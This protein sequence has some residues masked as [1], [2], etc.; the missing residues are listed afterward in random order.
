V[1]VACIGHLFWFAFQVGQLYTM[2]Q[3][4]TLYRKMQRTAIVS[5]EHLFLVL[6]LINT[7]E[8][9]YKRVFSNIEMDG[10]RFNIS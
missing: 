7:Q 9:V 8:W 1:I 4:K 10:R 6:F 3:Y 5:K 2:L